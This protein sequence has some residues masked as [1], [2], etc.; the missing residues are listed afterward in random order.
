MNNLK[1]VKCLQKHLAL[2]KS[3]ARE[4][5]DGHGAGGVP[6]HRDDIEGEVTNAEVHASL[7][8]QGLQLRI[9]NVRRSMQARRFVPVES[10]M[11]DLSTLYHYADRFNGLDVAADVVGAYEALDSTDI[12]SN[13]TSASPKKGCGCH[14]DDSDKQEETR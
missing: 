6:D 3:Y 11:D 9:R 8:D 1:C 14:K 12:T 7:I 13:V 10:D 5:L 2:A 4:V